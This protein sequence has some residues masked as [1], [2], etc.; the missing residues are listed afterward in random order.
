MTTLANQ[1]HTALL[2]ID[3]QEA[4]I[5]KAHMREAVPLTR[6]SFEG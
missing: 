1:T 5:E 4:A 3:M 6:S 2:V